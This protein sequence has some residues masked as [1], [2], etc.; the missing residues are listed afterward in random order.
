VTATIREAILDQDRVVEI[1]DFIAEGKEQY[2]SQTF[3]QHLMQLVAD[4]QVT[5]EVARA[6]ATNPGDFELKMRTLA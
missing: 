6:A 1:P 2:G 5:Y 4:D 3:D